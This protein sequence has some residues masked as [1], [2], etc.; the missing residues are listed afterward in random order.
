MSSTMKQLDPLMTAE[1]ERRR[2]LLKQASI[3]ASA[4][5]ATAL[6]TALASPVRAIYLLMGTPMNLPDI[7]AEIH[8]HDKLC[9]ANL[10]F[11]EGL[12]RDRHA[13][14]Y[15]AM[16]GADG[17]VSTKSE[18]LRTVG[19]FGMLSILR[20]FAIDSAAVAVTLK[21]LTQF[22][23]DVIEIL[24][25][26]VAPKVVTRITSSHSGIHIIA[27]GLIESVREIET[28]FFRRCWLGHNQRP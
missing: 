25:A 15:L 5:N 19:S 27:G 14:E 4:A 1:T 18:V 21:S 17:I 22:V 7:F 11:L 13:V 20:T 24:P 2:K 23:P 12:A 3:I 9:L 6:D 10:D 8:D 26:I 16:H 28:L